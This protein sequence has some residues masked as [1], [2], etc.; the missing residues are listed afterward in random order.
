MVLR[1]TVLLIALAHIPTVTV[2]GQS[3]C[4]EPHAMELGRFRLLAQVGAGRDGV[5]FRAEEASTGAC[6]LE[7][8]PVCS[9]MAATTAGALA[10]A[11]R[12]ATPG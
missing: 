6:G 7:E 4:T 5:R 12:R 9:S 1:S 2:L 8:S 11:G 10:M 3:T